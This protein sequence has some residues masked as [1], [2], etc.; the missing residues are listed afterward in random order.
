MAAEAELTE[1]TTQRVTQNSHILA[2][3][4]QALFW[5]SLPSGILSFVLP[6]YG[7]EIGAGALQIG[8]FFSIFFLMTVLLRPLVGAGLDRF[9]RRPFFIAGL[10]GYALSMFAFAY[11]SEDAVTTF[12]SQCYA[13]VRFLCESDYENSLES[14]C[15]MLTD[16]LTGNWPIEPEN[17]IIAADRRILLTSRWN[18]A[19]SSQMFKHYIDTDLE[20]TEKCYLEFCIK[21]TDKIRLNQTPANQFVDNKT[22]KNTD[23]TQ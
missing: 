12:Y 18:K 6:V 5:I 2:S 7:S 16:G 17:K 20:K 4:R 3:L 9:G 13:L 11:S 1:A 21:I 19:V 8:L 14:F 22:P 10:L 15:H 23:A